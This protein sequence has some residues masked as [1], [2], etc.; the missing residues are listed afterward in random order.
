MTIKSPPPHSPIDRIFCEL[1]ELIFRASFASDKFEKLSVVS[2]SIAKS[3]LLKFFLQLSWE[4]K[5]ITHKT[6][7]ELIL[8]VEEVGKM[9]GGWKKSILE[10]TPPM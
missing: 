4:H 5:I 7:A 2:Q 1:L 9:L 3:D 8:F 10:K 6:Y